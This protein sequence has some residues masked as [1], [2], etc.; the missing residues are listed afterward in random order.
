MRKR[1]RIEPVRH[2]HRIGG[3]GARLARPLPLVRSPTGWRVAMRVLTA[4]AL[5]LQFGNVMH[6]MPRP[7]SPEPERS[8]RASRAN[9]RATAHDRAPRADEIQLRVHVERRVSISGRDVGER[10]RAGSSA[11]AKGARCQRVGSS[12]RPPLRRPRNGPVAT[13]LEVVGRSQWWFAAVS[14][15][16]D[17]RSEGGRRRI[18]Q[19]AFEAAE[20]V[21]SP[22]NRSV[23]RARGLLQTLQ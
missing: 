16:R 23:E 18:V 4:S 11:V 12:L 14:A 17:S 15:A 9:R 8:S 5:A 3:R 19:G 13:H 20:L 1:I 22:R 6:Q 7:W 2:E 21:R 10:T